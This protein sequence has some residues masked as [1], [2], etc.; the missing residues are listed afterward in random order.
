MRKLLVILGIPIDDL[1]MPEALDRLDEFIRVG[2]ATGK[3]HQVATVNADFVV[4]STF[5]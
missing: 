3:S 1:T 5:R 2:R 4:N